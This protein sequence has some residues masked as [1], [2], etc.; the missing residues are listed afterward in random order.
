MAAEDSRSLRAVTLCLLAWVLMGLVSFVYHVA[1]SASLPA[2]TVNQ[3]CV[4]LD[5]CLR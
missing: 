4:V 3:L 5:S 2:P 1:E